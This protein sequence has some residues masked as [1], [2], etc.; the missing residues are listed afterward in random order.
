VIRLLLFLLNII[1]IVGL[2]VFVADRAGNVT[3]EWQDSIIEMSG[4]L[5]VAIVALLMWAAY[6][7]AQL[8]SAVKALPQDYRVHRHLQLQRRGHKMLSEALTAFAADR[9]NK[10]VSFLRRA[11]KLLGPSQVVDF[12]RLH[13]APPTTAAAD[14]ATSTMDYGSPYAWRQVVESHLADDRQTEALQIAKMFASKYPNLPL[15]KR[16]VFDAQVRRRNWEEALLVFE[17]L[18]AAHIMPRKLWR[19][20]KAALLTERAREQVIRGHMADAFDDAMQADRLNPDWAP[21][22]IIGAKALAAQDKAREAASLIERHWSKAANEQLGDIY[23]NLKVWKNP[24]QKAQSAEKMARRNPEHPASDLLLAQ[25]FMRANLW[26][27]ARHYGDVLVKKQ[28]SREVFE[29][30][31]HVEEAQ[32]RDLLTARDWRSKALNAPPDN[33]WVC[34]K[35]KQPHEHWQALCATCKSFD[36]LNWGVPPHKGLIKGR[37]ETGT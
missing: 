36:T 34:D 11:E 10:G 14:Q 35:C 20:Q 33:A 32:S 17:E 31:A 4:A 30:L 37:K 7:L 16:L 25:A 6:T 1:V 26:G 28:P 19:H 22:L 9:K 13:L 29:L 21:A 3:F 24:L 27:Q 15:A 12:V 2:A 8:M 23:L 5:L 18:R